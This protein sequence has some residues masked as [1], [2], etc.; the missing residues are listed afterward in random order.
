MSIYFKCTHTNT[1]ILKRWQIFATTS[2]RTKDNTL[3]CALEMKLMCLFFALCNFIQSNIDE[4]RTTTT[5]TALPATFFTI[6]RALAAAAPA[7]VTVVTIKIIITVAINI[8]HRGI[9]SSLAFYQHNAV[10]GA[11]GAGVRGLLGVHFKF[12]PVVGLP[13]TLLSCLYFFFDFF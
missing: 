6:H 3:V 9:Y 13:A 12:Q 8:A 2:T 10:V 7:T 4:E 5:P 11:G 1:R